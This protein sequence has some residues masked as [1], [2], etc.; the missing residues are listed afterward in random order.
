MADPRR[1]LVEGSEGGRPAPGAAEA[2]AAVARP[3]G[4]EALLMAAAADDESW[5]DAA[6]AGWLGWPMRA[7]RTA[8]GTE[9]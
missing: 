7:R 9:L 8:A 4:V 6:L 3:R 5:T 1:G 2:A